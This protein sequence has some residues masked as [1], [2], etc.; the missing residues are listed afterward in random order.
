MKDDLLKNHEAKTILTEYFNNVALGKADKTLREYTARTIEAVDCKDIK[1]RPFIDVV[2]SIGK[3]INP[4]TKSKTKKPVTINIKHVKALCRIAAEELGQRPCCGGTAPKKL[5]ILLHSVPVTG[6]K[7]N[8]AHCLNYDLLASGENECEAIAKI[9]KLITLVLALKED[10]KELGLPIAPYE[11][12]EEYERAEKPKYIDSIVDF[13][14][15][16][17]TWEADIRQAPNQQLI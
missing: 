12:W 10:P 7:K 6:S 15:Q 14:L 5:A 11:Y 9:R 4:S 16:G 3:H 2:K 1:L 17:C 13:C 8:T